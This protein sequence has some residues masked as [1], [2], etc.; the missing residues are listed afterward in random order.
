ME[1]KTTTENMKIKMIFLFETESKNDFSLYRPFS[2]IT[3]FTAGIAVFKVQPQHMLSLDSGP[4]SSRN[5]GW[6]SFS[7]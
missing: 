6:P 2:R 3:V 5:S 1:I 4:I 7:S